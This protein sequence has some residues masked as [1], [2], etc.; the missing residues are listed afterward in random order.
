MKA[1]LRKI[2]CI[3]GFILSV[4][5]AVPTV[6]WGLIVALI[7]KDSDFYLGCLSDN[8]SSE[9]FKEKVIWITGSS[10]G[11]GKSLAFRLAKISKD[12][13][14]ALY[15][16]LTSR[17]TEQLNQVKSEILEN[18]EF[19]EQNIL[20]L[21]LDV[22]NLLSIDS[23]VNEAIAWKG[24]IDILYNNAGVGQKSILG[25]FESDEKVMM[26]NALGSMKISREVLLKSFIP[27]KSGHLVNTISIQAFVA[28]P[29]RCA[30]GASK[31]ASLAFFQ[32]LRKELNY[33]NWDEYLEFNCLNSKGLQIN[34]ENPNIYITN[35]HPG[36]IQTNFDLRNVLYDGSSNGLNSNT[37]GMTSERCSEL[38]IKATTNRL[39]EAWIA[40]NL[41]LIFF[42]ITY[43][44][45]NISNF[46]HRFIDR[47]FFDEV[48]EL[49]KSNLKKST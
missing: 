11:I 31:R 6:V 40:K 49:Q 47:K 42:Y 36:H 13:D 2:A 16:I 3:Y 44:S 46:I 9:Y 27:Q 30:Y 8:I 33:V 4:I 35:I 24:R 29:G 45:P 17:D 20:I 32:S 10:S 12:F 21:P 18:F 48:W 25:R 37:I 1:F 43:Y 34:K 26:I 22:G 14:V 15:L 41:E 28:L 19:P 39:E 5:I 38:I 23:K 7:S